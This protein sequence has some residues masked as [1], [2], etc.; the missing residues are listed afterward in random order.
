MKKTL[1]A[2][3][4]EVKLKDVKERLA[5][6]IYYKEDYEQ[7]FMSYVK[8]FKF[9]IDALDNYV[10]Y[11]EESL[12]KLHSLV[13]KSYDYKTVYVDA[14]GCMCDEFYENKH[15]FVYSRDID[16]IDFI[17][18]S[19]TELDNQF[20]EEDSLIMSCINLLGDDLYNLTDATKTYPNKL[21]FEETAK[22]V[23]SIGDKLDSIIALHDA[24]DKNL[25]EMQDLIKQII[26]D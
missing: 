22:L 1:A 26:N 6:F 8:G 17:V 5:Q 23:D 24:N 12:L 19:I 15:K 18:E 9:D 25:H 14:I 7:V 20:V 10:S 11:L 3:K 2:F 21:V 13:F 4:A 16:F